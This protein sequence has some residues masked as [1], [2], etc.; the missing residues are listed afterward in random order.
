M[1]EEN[2]TF[3]GH[4]RQIDGYLVRPDGIGP[5]PAI[6]VLMEIWGVD[7]HIRDVAQRFAAQG[8]V[9]LAPDMYTDQYKEAMK[10]DNIMAGMMF[11]RQASPEIQRDPAKMAD[12]LKDRTPGEQT[13]LKALMQVMSSE[14]RQT[15]AEELVGA[16]DYLK[17]RPE[18][19]AQRIASLGFCFGGGL[20][21]NL[22]TLSPDLWKSVIFYGENPP[23]DRVSQIRAEVLALYGGKDRRITDLVPAFQR[24][25]DEADKP[26]TYK[27]YGNAQH[28]F[29]NDTRPMYHPYAAKDAWYEVL[30]F[31]NVG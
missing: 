12:A 5:H 9:A 6:I 25:M 22:A 19:D 15:F 2:I 13:A 8:F 1:R 24:A 4:G 30:R 27:V 7:G 29:F 20:S 3:V 23:L 10:P 28:A 11:L 21:A 14:T 26:F 31:L 18:V 16:V 17:K